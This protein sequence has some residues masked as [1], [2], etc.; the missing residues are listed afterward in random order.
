MGLC[1]CNEDPSAINYL[2]GQYL[3]NNIVQNLAR[4]EQDAAEFRV[5][6][7]EKHRHKF[8]GRMGIYDKQVIYGAQSTGNSNVL[9]LDPKYT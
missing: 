8:Y 3:S 2:D 6:Q 7:N 4:K 5:E 9:L 1:C